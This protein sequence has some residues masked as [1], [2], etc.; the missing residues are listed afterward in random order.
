MYIT[1]IDDLFDDILNKLYKYIIT[2]QILQ[3]YQ[4]DTNFVKYQNDI[5]STLQDFITKH[6]SKKDILD[7]VKNQTYYEFILATIKRYCAFYI[8]LSIAYYYKGGRDLYITNIIEL[9]KYQK[10]TE[11][12]IP[13]FYNSENNAKI[14]TAYNDIKNMLSI[15]Q[16]GRT[17]DKIKIILSNNP[18]KFDSTIK[19]FNELGEDYIID[20]FLINDNFH[21]ILKTLIFKQIYIK[22]EKD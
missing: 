4:A 1:Q 12:Q 10:D 21:N 22:E 2:N 13:N 7:L 3:K 6:T 11:F 19:L 16:A 18:V 9:S 8:Y 20:N 17:I 15:F 14:I 5:M